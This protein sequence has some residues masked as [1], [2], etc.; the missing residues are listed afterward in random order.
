M[1]WADIE[2]L[3]DKESERRDWGRHVTNPNKFVSVPLGSNDL[4]T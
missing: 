3:G 1:L 2:L 4:K